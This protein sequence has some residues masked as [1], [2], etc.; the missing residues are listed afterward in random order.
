MGQLI[1]L[2]IKENFFDDSYINQKAKFG[3]S[4]RFELQHYEGICRD[5]KCTN[6]VI[7]P[8]QKIPFK[9][10]LKKSAEGWQKRFGRMNIWGCSNTKKI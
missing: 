8:G 10:I 3:L 2:I 6:T 1:E 4:T 9:Q 7:G 5:T